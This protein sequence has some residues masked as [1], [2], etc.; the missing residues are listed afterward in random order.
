MK[1]VVTVSAELERMSSGMGHG[2]ELFLKPT[3]VCEWTQ[4]V[5]RKDG[6]WHAVGKA[7]GSAWLS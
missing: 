5:S 3:V 7:E 6:K 2:L 4:A 1:K